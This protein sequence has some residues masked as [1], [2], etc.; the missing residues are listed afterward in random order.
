MCPPYSVFPFSFFGSFAIY[1]SLFILRKKLTR[2]AIISLGVLA[3][4]S[5]LTGSRVPI[6]IIK[7]LSGEIRSKEEFMERVKR[8]NKMNNLRKID[9]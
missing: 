1:L 2:K 4:F 6:D 7:S 9:E 5:C 3:T 8:K